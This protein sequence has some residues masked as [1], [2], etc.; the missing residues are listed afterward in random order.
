[1]CFF[2]IASFTQLLL[3]HTFFKFFV[4]IAYLASDLHTLKKLQPSLCSVV[5]EDPSSARGD[6]RPKHR[7]SGHSDIDIQ[8]EVINTQYKE[9]NLEQEQATSWEES[10]LLVKII[11]A[12][13]VEIA[14]YVKDKTRLEEIIQKQNHQAEQLQTQINSLERSQSNQL[15]TRNSQ[16]SFLQNEISALKIALAK[17]R[18]EN[19]VI[20]LQAEEVKA[21]LTSQVDRLKVDLNFEKNRVKSLSDQLAT[22]K[23]KFESERKDLERLK[24]SR[25]NQVA[26][27]LWKLDREKN[28]NRKLRLVIEDDYDAIYRYHEE[29][30]RLGQDCEWWNWHCACQAN[31]IKELRWR[32][33]QLRNEPRNADFFLPH[34][35]CNILTHNKAFDRGDDNLK[36]F[37]MNVE[38]GGKEFVPSKSINPE[39]LLL[40]THVTREDGNMEGDPLS[41]KDVENSKR[42]S[43]PPTKSK[44]SKDDGDSGDDKK[45]VRFA[46][47]DRHVEF[48][49]NVKTSSLGDSIAADRKP[50]TKRTQ[51]TKLS[52]KAKRISKTSSLPKKSNLVKHNETT[53]TPKHR[54][55]SFDYRHNDASQAV[56]RASGKQQETISSCPYFGEEYQNDLQL[57]FV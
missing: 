12:Q 22:S 18:E 53:L 31:E 33:E 51:S 7:H 3:P 56:V 19:K 20:H 24:A 35:Q 44:M 34:R 28:E 13:K 4:Q 50:L 9:S 21:N 10:K 23:L 52:V 47:I 15:T 30:T 1:M 26:M 36:R 17:Q 49:P 27:L 54:S 41:D 32:I 5:P 37:D 40:L 14:R 16:I 57:Y 55:S 43:T 39:N 6:L 25:E 38:N 11:E 29:V 8:T 42:R 2:N 45:S 46:D 48:D